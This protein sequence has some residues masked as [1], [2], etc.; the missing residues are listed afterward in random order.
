M[1]E[2]KLI[3]KEGSE[4]ESFYYKQYGEQKL[5]HDKIQDKLNVIPSEWQIRKIHFDSWGDLEIT[6]KHVDKIERSTVFC[7]II[8]SIY[9]ILEEI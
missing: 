4:L 1:Q 7:E 5:T 2:V 9:R 8:T 3:I 6:I